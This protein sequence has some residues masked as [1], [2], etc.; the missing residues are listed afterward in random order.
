MLGL[1]EKVLPEATL[2]VL[3]FQLELSLELRLELSLELSLELRLE[4]SLK[5]PLKLPWKLPGTLPA[6]MLRLTASRAA[7]RVEASAKDWDLLPEAETLR[8]PDSVPMPVPIPAC[9]H[10]PCLGLQRDLPTPAGRSCP[11]A[12]GR[13]G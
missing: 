12:G 2:P 1:E 5:L 13:E 9:P 8:D 10:L 11:R 4:L 6:R 7:K 3:E